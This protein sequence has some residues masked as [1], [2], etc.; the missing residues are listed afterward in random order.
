MKINWGTGIFLFYSFFAIT[1]FYQVFKS[2]Q[3]DRSLVVDNY[4]E[5]DL[6]Y[7]KTYDK[8]QNAMNLSDPLEMTYYEGFHLIE[9]QFP[10][11]LQ[12]VSGKVLF[13]RPSTNK[14]DVILPV[15]VDCENVMDIYVQELQYGK[16]II[17]VD[18]KAQHVSYL[19]R[20]NIEVPITIEEDVLTLR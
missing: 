9:L 15:R 12:A 13:Y 19:N 10:K 16:W 5:E 11:N 3:Y 7:Q 1:L 17:E 8:L 2:T 6:A 14:L 18:W 20:F 4:Y